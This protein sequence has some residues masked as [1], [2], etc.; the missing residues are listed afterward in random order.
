MHLKSKPAT[1]ARL[2]HPA[3][4]FLALT[5]LLALT[6]GLAA[7]DGLSAQ[8]DSGSQSAGHDQAEGHGHDDGH[9]HADTNEEDHEGHDHGAEETGDEGHAHGGEEA[10]HEGHEHGHEGPIRLSDEQRKEFGITVAA[11]ETGAVTDSFTLPAEVHYNGDRLAHVVPRVSGIATEVNATEGDDVKKGELLAVLDSRELADAKSDYLADVERESLQEISFR[12]EQQ[13]WDKKITSERT[14]LDAKSALAEARIARRGA[15][16][17][18]YAL[19]ISKDQVVNIKN[20]KD[21]VL[22]AY[23]LTAPFDGH[24]VKRHITLGEYIGADRQ[25]FAVADLSSVWIDLSVFPGDLDRIEKGQTVDIL[26]DQGNV[27]AQETIAFVTPQIEE[28]TRTAIARIIADPVG[29]RL[30]PGMFLT[31]RVTVDSGQDAVKVPRAAVQTIE[32]KPAVFVETDEGFEPRNVTLGP[33]G[34][35]DIVIAEGLKPGEKIVT[36]GAFTL[37]AEMSKGSFGG[38]HH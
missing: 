17:K 31:A 20:E 11:A 2:A 3:S 35:N 38:H 19:G 32:D 29:G 6:S 4:V 36:E 24:V 14:F 8:E 37:K 16:Q 25:A 18:L 12:R 10:G 28:G 9:P 33:K 7:C 22:T 27:I 15:E 26:D 5:A 30:R 23:A 1:P 21:T 13:L 34:E